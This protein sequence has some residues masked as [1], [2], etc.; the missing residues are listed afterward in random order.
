MKVREKVVCLGSHEISTGE[1]ESETAKKGVLS[2]SLP[3]WGTE[4]YPT[5]ELWEEASHT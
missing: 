4:T 2:G 3:P 5:R 1:V